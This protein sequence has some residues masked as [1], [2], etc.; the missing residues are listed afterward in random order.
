MGEWGATSQWVQCF[1]WGDENGLLGTSGQD[2]G[3]SKHSSP[4]KTTSKHMHT[5]CPLPGPLIP[6]PF[7]L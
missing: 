2:G 7:E 5:L 1:I 3:I 6:A 4:Q